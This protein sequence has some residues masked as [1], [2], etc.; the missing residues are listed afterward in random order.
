MGESETMRIKTS[1]LK[2][3]VKKASLN[4]R[5]MFVNLDF[6]KDGVKSSVRD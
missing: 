2:S 6:T 1:V 3:F 4:G 5:I